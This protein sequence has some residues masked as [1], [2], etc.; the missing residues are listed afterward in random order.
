[1]RGLLY[2]P[3][4]PVPETDPDIV[5]QFGTMMSAI[6]LEKKATVHRKRW[7]VNFSSRSGSGTGS[8]G[9][10]PGPKGPG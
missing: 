3:P 9:K 5:N 1:M 4:D 6:F 7:L 8:E 2:S 10:K